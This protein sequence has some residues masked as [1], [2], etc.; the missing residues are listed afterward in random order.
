MTGPDATNLNRTKLRRLLAAVGSAP[1]QED[2]M[3]EALVYD[4]RDPHFF[5]EEQRNRLAAIMSQVAAMLSERF[6]HFFNGD[7]NVAPTSITQHFAA[8]LG[9]HV[10]LEQAIS[11]S[12]GPEHKP[13]CGFCT[14]T[15]PTA[16][17]WVTRLLGDTESPPDPD[18][19]LSPLEQSLLADLVGAITEAFLAPL[20]TGQPLQPAG[21]PTRGPLA[22]PFDPTDPLCRIVFQIAQPQDEHDARPEITFILDSATLAPS[23]GK[24]IQTPPAIAP[25]ELANLLTEHLHQMPVAIT[26]QLASTRFSF[27]E[28]LDL[29]PGDVL[30]IDKPLDEPVELIINHRTVFRGRPAQSDAH[31]A[32]YITESATE[33]DRENAT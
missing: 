25:D 23:L 26:A 19:A 15:A 12:F 14:V 27:E 4:W 11:L 30:L 29:A 13:P 5:N 33:P 10:D 2:A 6:A 24:T 20:P 8:D 22:V 1:V 28:I 18:R 16:L 31:Y 17:D 7:F 3:P 9:R 32:V 21:Q